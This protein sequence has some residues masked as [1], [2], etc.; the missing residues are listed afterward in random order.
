MPTRKASVL[1][2]TCLAALVV[3]FPFDSRAAAQGARSEAD[4]ET[5]SVNDEQQRNRF[6]GGYE[7]WWQRKDIQETLGLTPEQ[8]EQLD[9]LADSTR[10]YITASKDARNENFR[11]FSEALI[12]GDEAAQNLYKERMAAGVEAQ[13]VVRAEQMQKGLKLLSEQQRD[14]L[15]SDFAFVYKQSWLASGVTARR[16]AAA[17][18]VRVR[19]GGG[20]RARQ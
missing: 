8:V 14:Q 12:S 20:P 7:T 2:G 5:V 4:G 3:L 18:G 10:E 16:G 1:L 17:A 9:A 11:S 15:A 6:R 19:R 13:A